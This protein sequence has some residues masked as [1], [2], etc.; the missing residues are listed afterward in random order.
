METI[1]TFAGGLGLV[2]IGIKLLSATIQ[3]MAGRG[4]RKRLARMTESYPAAAALG[5]ASGALT[6]NIGAVFFTLSGLV[7]AD[8]I[9]LRRS[10]DVLSWSYIGLS[11]IIFIVTLDTRLFVLFILGVAGFLYFFDLHQAER[12]RHLAAALLAAGLLMLGILLVGEATALIQTTAWLRD[13]IALANLHPLIALGVGILSGVIM[14][15]LVSLSVVA[16]SLVSAG[17]LDFLTTCFLLTGGAAG[18]ISTAPLYVA[19][20][21]RGTQTLAW[22]DLINRLLGVAI[23]TGLLILEWQHLAAPVTSLTTAVAGDDLAFRCAVLFLLL[24]AISLI[25]ALAVRD[26]VLTLANRFVR[27]SPLGSLAAPRYLPADTRIDPDTAFDLAWRELAR[28]PPQL[29]CMT[30][31]VR[32]DA[33]SRPDHPAAVLHAANQAL[34]SRVESFVQDV[35]DRSPSRPL[36]AR[37]TE[38]THRLQLLRDLS[39]SVHDFLG[40]VIR[41]QA[42]PP[43]AAS[44]QTLVESLHLVLVSVAEALTAY[45]TNETDDEAVATAHALTGDRAQVMQRMRDR[46][47]SAATD[48][49]RDGHQA[50]F[51]LT[52]LFDRLIWLLRRLLPPARQPASL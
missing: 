13:F 24:Q 31:T 44:V 1:I 28:I 46:V 34:A 50:L 40:A 30:E 14:P 17:A 52:S 20:M 11:L 51:D 6:Q 19:R 47:G 7:A 29:I 18:Y 39:D 27:T 36:L 32:T 26:A 5:F 35:L 21:D 23:V 4:F 15:S 42:H 10:A 45:D 12:T 48:L 38:L 33:D 25:F 43:L 8:A 3:Q 22:F 9:S 16:V 49:S 41:A 2:F 37:G